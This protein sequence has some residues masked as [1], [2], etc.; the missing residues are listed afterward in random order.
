MVIYNEKG[1]S[2][3]IGVQDYRLVGKLHT[4]HRNRYRGIVVY[5]LTKREEFVIRWLGRL[6][7][8]L[9]FGVLCVG[10]L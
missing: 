6:V 3:G 9:V 5:P 7:V 1:G 4:A 10:S 2:D 8:V